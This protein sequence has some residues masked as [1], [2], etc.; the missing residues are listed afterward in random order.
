MD[1]EPIVNYTIK[2]SRMLVVNP[3]VLKDMTP[4]VQLL[5]FQDSGMLLRL[6]ALAKDQPTAFATACELRETMK[7]DFDANGIEIPYTQD[8]RL[9]A[10]ITR[11]RSVM[12]RPGGDELQ[13]QFVR[14]L[15]SHQGDGRLSIRL[16]GCRMLGLPIGGL[17][18]DGGNY[19]GENHGAHKSSIHVLPDYT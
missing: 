1:E 4:V 5:E 9:E 6:L 11:Q 8:G 16:N 12:R 3:Q 17:E 10:R 13:T 15:R 19:G 7:N 18:Q 14:A 2:D